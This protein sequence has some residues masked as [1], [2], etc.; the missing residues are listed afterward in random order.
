MHDLDDLLTGGEALGHLGADRTLLDPCDEVL[1]NN[2]VDVR[3]EKRDP[4]LAQ[5][6]VHI[7]FGK[8]DLAA[9]PV[10]EAPNAR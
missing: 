9:E 6:T 1:D 3:L 5:R 7:V 8:A 10:E 4:D 2:E